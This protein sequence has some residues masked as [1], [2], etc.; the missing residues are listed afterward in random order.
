MK[1]HIPVPENLVD[2]YKNNLKEINA[3]PI[4]KVIEAK[5]RKKKRT[6]KKMEKAK[7]KAEAILDKG[8]LTDNEKASQIKQLY[9][10]AK[11]TKKKEVTYVVA[12]KFNSGK[13]MSRPSGVKGPMK[14]VDPRMK[15]DNRKLR[16][17]TKPSNKAGKKGKGFR[18]QSGGK[19]RKKR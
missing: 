16:T 2:E 5:A 13:R 4:K 7:K 3:R 14:V 17:T 9:K 15:K 11:Q 10:K 12:K 18:Q 1:K 19:G 6:I 8:E